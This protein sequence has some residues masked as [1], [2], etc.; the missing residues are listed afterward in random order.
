MNRP[1]IGRLDAIVEQRV[2]AFSRAV[3]PTDHDVLA[4]PQVQGLRG[5][6]DSQGHAVARGPGDGGGWIA[7]L[8]TREHFGGNFTAPPRMHRLVERGLG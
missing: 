3:H 5:V 6:G 8:E 7:C 1:P 4:R 2:N